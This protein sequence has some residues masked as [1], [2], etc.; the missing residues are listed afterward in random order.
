MTKHMS[1]KSGLVTGA[2]SGIGRAS[3]LA[4]AKA[5]ANVMVSDMNEVSGKETVQ[6]IEELGGQAAFIKCDVSNE[7]QVKELIEATVSTFG[8][9]DFAH[10]NAGITIPPT[11][12]GETPSEDWDR[13]VKIN[14]YG[15]HFCMKHELE[16][17]KKQGGGTIVNTASGTGLEGLPNMSSYSATKFG[18]IGLTKCAAIEYGRNGVRVNAIAPGTTMSPMI[19]NL[20]VEMPEQVE[21][22]KKTI[23]SGEFATTEDQGNAAVF[24]CSDFA[25]QIN[26][27]VLPVDG[28]L[29]AGKM[30]N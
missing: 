26:G 11:T 17:M 19:E 28:G 22:V 16:V 4:F 8:K 30:Q 18:I 23:P 10:N 15:T 2:G 6:L 24:L 29:V 20:M 1:G 9:I 12:L 21:A 5:G 3:A 14:L 25:P 13:I 7:E 27:V